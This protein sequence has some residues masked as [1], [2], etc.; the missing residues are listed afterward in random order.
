MIM[1]RLSIF[2]LLFVSTAIQATAAKPKVV[3]SA[4]MIADMVQV[5]GSDFVDVRCI[6]PIG[7]D[8]HTYEPTPQD[9]QLV[10]QADLILLNGLTFEGWINELIENSGTKA[11]VKIVTDSIS[12]I[13]SST[14]ENASDPH[15]WMDATNGIIYAE[16]ISNALGLVDKKN[17]EIYQSNFLIYRKELQ[18]LDAYIFEQIEQ[19]PHNQRVLITSHDAF[20]YYG[21]RYGLQLESILGTSTDA[22]AQTSDII[23]LNRVIQ[24]NRVPSVFIES[25][26]N[27]Q[28]LEQLAKDNGI[29]VGGKL[30]S[31]SIGDDNSEAPTYIDML[32][33]NTKTIVKA[34]KEPLPKTSEPRESE[35]RSNILLWLLPIAAL[36][37]LVFWL[38]KR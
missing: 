34:L 20:Q 31:D 30:F 32:R 6:V 2:L 13:L 37:I 1:M 21:R 8:P 28:L 10:A 14:Y 24:A 35:T 19:I 27:P 7:G 22:E 5:L 9:A 26:V 17:A 29:K 23:R 15:A 3:A 38:W 11:I 33:Y 4:S 12:V 25:T 36:L 18:D 16:N